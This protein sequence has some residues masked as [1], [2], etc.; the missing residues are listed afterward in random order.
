MSRDLLSVSHGN[1]LVVRRYHCST[2]TPW[3]C[4]KTGEEQHGRRGLERHPPGT[5]HLQ[6][7]FLHMAVQ[8]TEHS[9][10]YK[11]EQLSS[12]DKH[13]DVLSINQHIISIFKYSSTSI[14]H[15]CHSWHLFH[16]PI[17]CVLIIIIIMQI[18]YAPVSKIESDVRIWLDPLKRFLQKRFGIS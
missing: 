7:L 9:L 6:R 2:Y 12:N 11:Q 17:F 3:K 8:R 15:K 4:C 16:K 5:Q 14:A 10:S 1:L 18:S 13:L